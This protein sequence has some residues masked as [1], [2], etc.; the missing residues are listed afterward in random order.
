[1]YREA[2]KENIAERNKKYHEENKEKMAANARRYYEANVARINARNKK[3]YEEHKK[4][5]VAQIKR[6]HQNIYEECEQGVI[7]NTLIHLIFDFLNNNIDTELD[8]LRLTFYQNNPGS[9][10][11]IYFWWV[12]LTYEKYIVLENESLE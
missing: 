9:V 12:K 7:K 4:E 8:K 5:T 2:N 3:Y 1:M 6:Y 11:S 10:S